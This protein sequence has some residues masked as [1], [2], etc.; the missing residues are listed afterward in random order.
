MT[1]SIN[2]LAALNDGISTVAGRSGAVVITS[3]DLADLLT[4]NQKSVYAAGTVYTL[5]NAAAA[6]AF[7]TTSPAI[8]LDKAGT[9]KIDYKARV[10][11]V[12]ATFAASRLLT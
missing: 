9:Y 5:T 8:T 10:E 1:V 2:S 7:G 6:V 4:A 11:N 3:A 12:G